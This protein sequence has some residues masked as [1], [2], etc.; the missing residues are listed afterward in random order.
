MTLY[1]R[2]SLALPH[3]KYGD[4]RKVRQPGTSWIQRTGVGLTVTSTGILV[5]PLHSGQQRHTTKEA[6]VSQQHCSA[7]STVNGSP[8]PK[9]LSNSTPSQSVHLETSWSWEMR[10][11]QTLS[12][13]R[14]F[15]PCSIPVAKLQS[16]QDLVYYLTLPEVK[17]QGQNHGGSIRPCQGP[18]AKQPIY[19]AWS[20]T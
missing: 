10:P 1:R 16:I 6:T 8:R 15:W 3:E 4:V 13:K 11:G 5:V 14:N 18:V 2:H 9:S 19:Q 20:I 17:K 7:E 12:T